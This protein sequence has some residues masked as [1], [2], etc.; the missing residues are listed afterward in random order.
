M[1]E[2]ERTGYDCVLVEGL[3]DWCLDLARVAPECKRAPGV[4]V[5]RNGGQS[6]P[7]QLGSSTWFTIVGATPAQ[8]NGRILQILLP[9]WPGKLA[10]IGGGRPVPS[11]G[12]TVARQDEVVGEKGSALA[13]A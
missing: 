8:E 11:G 2:R 5:P 12:P 9:R 3:R 13:I 1:E 6:S 10:S 7:Y 4:E